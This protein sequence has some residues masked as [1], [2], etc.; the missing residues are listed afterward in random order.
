V[1]Q[2]AHGRLSTEL[3]AAL[4]STVAVG[5]S[6]SGFRM[7][8]RESRISLLRLTMPC[9]EPQLCLAEED[10]E[11][12]LVSNLSNSVILA[13]DMLPAA[14]VHPLPVPVAAAFQ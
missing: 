8:S 12:L 13:P 7:L 10:F 2:A 6:S 1:M 11:C 14:Q 4:V 9:L 5:D 3:W